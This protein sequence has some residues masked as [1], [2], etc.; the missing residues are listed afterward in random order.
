MRRNLSLTTLFLKS[1]Q[2]AGGRSRNKSVA[3]P[4][5]AF[6]NS[7]EERM[8]DSFAGVYGDALGSSGRG[9]RVGD[10]EDRF[11]GSADEEFLEVIF[12]AC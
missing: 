3:P 6:I 9:G 8:R 7:V 10:G 2:F 12:V 4:T 11:C 1:K 5:A